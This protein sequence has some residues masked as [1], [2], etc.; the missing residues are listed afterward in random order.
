[1]DLPALFDSGSLKVFGLCHIAVMASPDF[2]EGSQWTG[3]EYW[4]YHSSDGLRRTV[5]GG[6]GADN[7]EVQ[8][9]NF[10]KPPRSS[11]NPRDRYVERYAR[12]KLLRWDDSRFYVLQ[13][14]YF[15]SGDDTHCL[16]LRVD[17]L[18]GIIKIIRHVNWDN[19]PKV[20]L[21][22]CGKLSGA[23]QVTSVNSN[24]LKKALPDKV[25]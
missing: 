13:S 16:T 11:E 19:F 17:M 5:W 23:K 14:N 12:F 7:S 8:L 4:C 1:M 10:N 18:T 24:S 22:G 6:I 3:Y 21:G 20:D 15:Q 25:E 9:N 2:F